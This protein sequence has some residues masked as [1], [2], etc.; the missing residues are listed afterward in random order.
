MTGT[1]RRQDPWDPA[2]ARAL[3]ER[4]VSG[5]GDRTMVEEI[6]TADAT[7]AEPGTSPISR[8]ITGC[9]AIA[10]LI[11]EVIA[12]S[13]GTFR[14]IEIE[15]IAVG[16]RY[17]LAVIVVEAVHRS[18]SIRTTDRVVF[19]FTDGRVSAVHVA[20]DDQAEVDEFWS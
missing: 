8:R 4:F 12:R 9:E 5:Y 10:D 14:I 2:A 3:I 18:R 15:E 7:W 16:H 13:D 11:D 17:G 20:S 6:F 1:A 19:T